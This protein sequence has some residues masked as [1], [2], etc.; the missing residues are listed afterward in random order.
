MSINEN[1]CQQKLLVSKLSIASFIL[2]VLAYA[3]LIFILIFKISLK[4]LLAFAPLIMLFSLTTSLIL[5]IIDL[6]RKN[7]K[8]IL[9]IIATVLSG[10]YF[11]FIIGGIAVTLLMHK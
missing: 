2:A 1:I 6:R 3:I 7:R 5:S 9:S 11:L 10:L 4:A 8:K